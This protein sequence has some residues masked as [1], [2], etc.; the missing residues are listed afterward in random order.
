MAW[1]LVA[2]E[3]PDNIHPAAR[4]AG[5]P[6]GYEVPCDHSRVRPYRLYRTDGFADAD[7]TIDERATD[8]DPGRLM[9]H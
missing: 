3:T 9:H 5:E 6:R 2:T 4:A 1:H 8:L 7:C